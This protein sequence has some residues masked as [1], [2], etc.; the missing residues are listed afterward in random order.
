MILVKPINPGKFNDKAMKA[1]I[2][3]E[4]Q[5]ISKDIL[6]DFELTTA[7]WEHQV[8]F[9]RLV[10]VGPDKVEILVGTDD[11][12]YKYVDEGT[13]PHDIPKYKPGNR[14]LAFPSGYKAKT[15]PGKLSS[16]KGGSF[17]PMV[18]AMASIDKPIK[19]P[20]TKARNFDKN[21]KK[22]WSPKMK[23]RMEAAM[24]KANLASGYAYGE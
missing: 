24:R 17:G 19:H 18:F 11:E 6:L 3:A 12:I 2:T 10:E 1:I 16:Q 7:T 21:L 20:G 8:K 9:E 15:F 13:K 22:L 4:V 14:L 5:S 23:R